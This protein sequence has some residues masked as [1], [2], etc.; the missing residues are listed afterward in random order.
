[1]VHAATGGVLWFIYQPPLPTVVRNNQLQWCSM[2]GTTLTAWDVKDDVFD[3][4]GQTYHEDTALLP[5]D[6]GFIVSPAF[7]CT[8][9]FSYHH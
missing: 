5:Q 7:S 9:F 1:M 8:P 2:W 3:C 4:D 6:I